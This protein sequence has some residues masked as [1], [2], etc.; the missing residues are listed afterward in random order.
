MNKQEVWFIINPISGTK[1]NINALTDYIAKY[2]SLERY[3]YSLKFTEYKNHAYD[4]ANKAVEHS[5][6]IIV[7]VGGDGTINEI[8]KALIG[9]SIILGII[10][11]G[12][13]N[14]LAKHLGISL[15]VKLAIE[16]LNKQRLEK[17]DVGYIND[18][19]FLTASGIGFDAH[20]AKIFNE[21]KHNR[22]IWNFIRIVTYE[23]C[24]NYKDIECDFL[25]LKN[26][27]F[28]ITFCNVSKV[29]NNLYLAPDA[30]SNDGLLDCIA[31]KPYPF[32]ML[33]RIL[34][35]IFGKKI[36][37]SSHTSLLRAAEFDVHIDS[38]TSIHCDGEIYILNKPIIQIRIK[39]SALTVIA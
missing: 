18:L 20:C 10:P 2:I 37:Q 23:Y 14:G 27:F 39:P 25:G 34:G 11:V 26:K 38:D 36:K 5:V 29:G 7:A 22:G 15:D 13:G 9:H 21:K 1:N 35:N 33:R 8:A 17:L 24:F 19:P 4:I 16:G 32:L 12:S 28:R 30:L 31:V 3:N 6:D